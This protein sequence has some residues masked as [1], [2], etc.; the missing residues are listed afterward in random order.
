M[1]EAGAARGRGPQWGRSRSRGRARGS[2]AIASGASTQS[3]R[4]VRSECLRLRLPALQ[5]R[6]ASPSCPSHSIFSNTR[7]HYA[8][9]RFHLLRVPRQPAGAGS[10]MIVSPADGEGTEP[11]SAAERVRPQCQPSRLHICFRVRLKNLRKLHGKRLTPLD[12][13]LRRLGLMDSC[14]GS[15]LTLSA[16]STVLP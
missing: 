4:P 13:K 8:P 11:G 12:T 6:C 7:K 10:A 14:Q 15:L 1:E 9:L 2:R 3:P 16:Q 5:C